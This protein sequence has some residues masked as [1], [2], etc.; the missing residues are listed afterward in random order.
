[1]SQTRVRARHR[2]I[3]DCERCAAQTAPTSLRYALLIGHVRRCG[4]DRCQQGS[5]DCTVSP[6][7]KTAVQAKIWVQANYVDNGGWLSRIERRTN[8]YSRNGARVCRL[9]HSR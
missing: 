4:A 8:G 9:L 6:C 3:A 5:I 1:M 7:K 2:R